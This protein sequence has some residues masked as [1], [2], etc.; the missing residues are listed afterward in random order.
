GLAPGDAVVR[1]PAG[2]ATRRLA[3]RIDD[4]V[5]LCAGW[6]AER[7]ASAAADSS[8]TT[9]ITEASDEH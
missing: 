5:R 8:A 6:L 9:T 1:W 7:K 3:D 4:A 2:E